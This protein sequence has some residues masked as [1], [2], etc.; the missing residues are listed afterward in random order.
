MRGNKGADTFDS[1]YYLSANRGKKSITLDYSTPDGQDIIRR[2]AARADILVENYMVDLG[3][4][5]TGLR[6]PESDQSPPDLLFDHWIRPG[7]PCRIARGYDFVFQGMGGFMG[8]TGNAD[9]QPGGEP[10]KVG[11]A[12]AD[13]L[14]GMYATTAMLAALEYSARVRARSAY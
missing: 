12:A 13:I 7:S 14:T 5:R 3:P 1:S 4:V 6:R 10:M 11:I 9:D 2:L 8:L